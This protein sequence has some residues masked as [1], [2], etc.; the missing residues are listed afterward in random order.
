MK[1]SILFTIISVFIWA[2]LN[3]CTNLLVSS[4]AA[5]NNHVF[6]TYA[7]DSHELYGE[8]YFWPAGKH[9]KGT[10]LKIIEWDTG[11]YLGMIEQAPVTYRVIG[12]INEYQVAIG[13]TTFG[14]R[15]EL[16]NSEAVLD[17]GSL[18]YI[19]LQRA[20]SAREA[21][22]VMTSLVEKYGYCSSGE[23]FSIAD[24][25]E[26]WIM[27]IIGKGKGQ[28][29]AIWVA[30]RVPDGYVS[31]HANQ[32]R[33]G[34]FPLKDRKN[35]LYSKD[36]ISFAKQKGYFSG[37]DS[38]F[39]FKDVYAPASFGAKR[40]CDARVWSFY[41]KIA[42][43]KKISIDYVKGVE[44][45]KPL[46]L[47]IKPD[48]KINLSTLFACMRDHFEGTEFDLSRGVGA[49]PYSLP[50]RWRPLVWEH[51][52]KKYFNER[53]ISTQQTGFSFIA[54][55][56]SELPDKIGGVMWFGVDDTN[57]SVYFPVYCGSKSAPYNFAVGTGDFSKFSWD[58]GFWVFNFVSNFAYLRYADMI[59]DIHE[60]QQKFEGRF[61]A[62]QQDVDG[63]A[64]ALY[65]KAAR[66]AED[67]LT[68]Y[69]HKCADEVFKEWKKL[70]E[71]LMYKYLDGNV[72]DSRGKVT[73]PGYSKSWYKRIVQ[74][75]GDHYRMKK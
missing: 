59:K 70:G 1:K 5:K 48:E 32:A 54:Q 61:I 74:E 66:L 13:E 20:K 47:W 71:F 18:M 67:Y 35:W 75:N 2:S 17:Y 39:S 73:H 7:V 46:P 53:A 12:N 11:K 3:P 4:G 51:K 27:E 42:P 38:E 44:G 36:I 62:E 6:I 9:K 29:G 40:F 65:R 34:N 16:K 30:G 31:A 52:D 55:L 69:S 64:T 15:D 45:A 57:S 24:K 23:S 50:Y 26:V 72:K 43:S 49:G 28:M 37:K 25:N 41:N 22:K 63:A 21:I 19:A 14:G 33:I 58:S 60:V 10:M 68:D 56:R 8:M